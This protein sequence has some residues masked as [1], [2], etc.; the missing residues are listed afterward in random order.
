MLVLRLEDY[1]GSSKAVTEKAE[2]ELLP[3]R[4]RVDSGGCMSEAWFL[5]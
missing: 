5:G 1:T 3:I 2:L 4:P